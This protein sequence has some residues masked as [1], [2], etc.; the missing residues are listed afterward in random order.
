VLLRLLLPTLAAA[1]WFGAA[2]AATSPAHDL[3][4]IDADAWLD[5]FVP[6]AL[7]RCDVAGAIVVVVRDGQAL[8]QRGYGYADVG[9][10]KPVDA[11]TT[12]FRPGSISKLFTWT[13][14]M[15]LFEQGKIDLDVDVNRY[16]DFEIPPF[17][18]QR[19][20]SR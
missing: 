4:Q 7:S 15:Q 18:G 9:E 13:A 14:V 11:A 20:G 2:T 19:G 17:E 1:A 12:M 3:T 8:T 16:L 6:Y 10:R 5:G